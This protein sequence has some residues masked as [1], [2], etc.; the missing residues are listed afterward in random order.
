MENKIKHLEMI[1]AVV[2]RMADNSFYLKGWTITL[3]VGLFAFGANIGNPICFRLAFLPITVFGFLDIF[4]LIKE[5]RFV[6]L[7]ESVRL[8]TETDFSMDIKNF[9]EWYDFFICLI[10]LAI[11]PFYLTLLVVV[12]WASTYLL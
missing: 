11:W 10:S 3:V 12:Y 9:S 5:K 4:Y 6:K 7:Y 2:K 1:Q 8:K